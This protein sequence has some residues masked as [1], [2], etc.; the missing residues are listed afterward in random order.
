[1]V[2]VAAALSGLGGGQEIGVI[3]FIVMIIAPYIIS[4]L[5]GTSLFGFAPPLIALE[6]QTVIGAI[7][8]NIHLTGGKQ[9]RRVVTAFAL[10]PIVTFGLQIL[11]L[12]SA[13]SFV[14]ALKWPSWAGFVLSTA[15]ASLIAFF[16]Q[17]YWMIFVTVLYFDC[18]IRKEGLDVRYLADNLVYADDV[19]V[20]AATAVNNPVIPTPSHGVTEAM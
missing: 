11:I 18:R 10:L 5:V 3:F 13:Q 7:S 15:L 14:E 4:V 17:P 2:F 6:N 9:Y 19:L 1:M 16:F 12:F 20:E 8:R